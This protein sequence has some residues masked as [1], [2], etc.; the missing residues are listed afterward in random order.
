MAFTHQQ[1]LI[2]VTVVLIIAAAA[3]YYFYEHKNNGAPAASGATASSSASA[4]GTTSGSGTAASSSGSA[5][6]TS[7]DAASQQ[8][9][10]TPA[11]TKYIAIQQGGLPSCFTT[12]GGS[13]LEGM[14][15]AD[16]VDKCAASSN[17]GG[18]GQCK[19]FMEANGRRYACLSTTTSSSYP[20]TYPSYIL[21]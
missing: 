2:A 14:S 11:G 19:G 18:N 16:A 1:I 21:Q 9:L 15:V 20:S 5:A 17:I 4:A 7:S 10:T 3:Y 12:T 13:T 6:S 8:V